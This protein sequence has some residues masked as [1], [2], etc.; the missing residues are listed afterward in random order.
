MTF[1]IDLWHDLR[2]KRLWPVAVGLL[3][4]AIAIPAVMLKPAAAPT[5][6]PAIA[7]GGER[8]ILPAIDVDSSPTRNSKLEAFSQRNPFKPLEQLDQD[9]ANSSGSDSS[10]GSASSPAGGGSA[11]AA[12]SGSGSSGG[13]S[14][15]TAPGASSG[16]GGGSTEPGVD[17]N[18][19]GVQ[20][21]RYTADIKFG[22]PGHLKTRKDIQTLTLL[23]KDDNAAIVFMGVSE[24]AKSAIFFIADPGFRAEGEGECNS[25]DNCRFVK[26]GVSDG[27]NEESFISQ[28]GTV[29]YDLELLRLNRENISSAEAKGDTTD[30][31]KPSSK[32]AGGS[33]IKQAG[34][35][36]LPRLL[37]GPGIA[38]ESK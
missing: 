11:S 1:F 37:Y 14:S 6:P 10:G 31:S 17:P 2:E 38:S 13:S 5:A 33:T 28:D 29:Q 12:G 7:A 32:D 22:A 20:W 36:F 24:D 27:K 16:G 21:F 15:D 25:E 26:L 35:E 3:A 9:D 4:A 30:S 23:P 34:D 19:S 8:E 18:G